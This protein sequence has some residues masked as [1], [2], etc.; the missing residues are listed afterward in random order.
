MRPQALV[1]LSAGVLFATACGDD[2]GS[3][4]TGSAGPKTVDGATAM[5]AGGTVKTWATIDAAGKVQRIGLTIPAASVDGASEQADIHLALPSEVLSET[6]FNH[7]G[8][9]FNPAGHGPPPYM[10]P[11]FDF[12]FYGIDEATQSSIDC[13]N[14]P[15][16][17][18]MYLPAPYIIPGTGTEP[19]GTCV[20]N[21]GVHAV[22]PTS[23][24][25]NPDEPQPFTETLIL[26]YHAGKLAFLEPMVTQQFLKERK[27]FMI[28]VPAP[29]SLGRSATWPSK[30]SMRFD[31][32]ANEYVIELY[33]FKPAY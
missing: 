22:N 1:F 26:G 14:E 24:E 18:A 28:D 5:L 3:D 8:I 12:H 32:D 20:P 21:M 17:D 31:A 27:A 29:Q 33:E 23:P 9:D 13:A 4:T 10:V 11:H 19:N 30:L 6:Y 15:M 2:T 25:L 16:P 7:V